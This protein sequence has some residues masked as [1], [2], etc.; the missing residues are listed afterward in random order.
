M[1]RTCKQNGDQ[2]ASTFFHWHFRR[3]ISVVVIGSTIQKCQRLAKIQSFQISFE[4]RKVVI[5]DK[6]QLLENMFS[7]KITT[8]HKRPI[9]RILTGYQALFF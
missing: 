5:F 8:L 2:S 6:L 3:P 9:Q 4:E 1:S 7:I